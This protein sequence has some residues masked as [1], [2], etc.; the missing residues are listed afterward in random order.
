MPTPISATDTELQKPVNVIFQASFLKQAMPCA[1]Y[2]LGTK[3]GQ[4]SKNGGSATVK[5]RRINALTPST[6]ALSELTGNASYMQ[7]RSSTTLGTTDVTATVAK[8]GEFVILNEEV[9]VFSFSTQMNEIFIALGIM[10][11][12]SANMLQRNIVEDNATLLY[13]SG[14]SDGDTDSAITLNSIKS[15]VNRLVKNSARTFSPSANGSQN[16]GTTPILKS[17]WG[18]CHPDVASDIEGLAGFKGVETYAGQV[19]TMSGE[20]GYL[21][22]NGYGVRFVQSEDA[23][24]DSGLGAATSSTGLRGS[25]NIDLYTTV[26]YGQEAL[27]SVGLGKSH[28]DGIYMAGDK[29]DAI[30]IIPKDRKQGG[31]SDPLEEISTIGYKFW[32]AGAVL[33]SSWVR[34]IRSGATDIQA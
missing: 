16:V 23:S 4:L 29:L 9:D 3:S 33:N 25:T 31:T 11:G 10:A 1:P 18:L 21:K 13:A 30:D 32:H 28:T 6:T 15:V 2:F 20:F 8:Y 27:G 24:L 7:G 26:I 19:A 34:G 14:T 22:A 12:R 5:W 17:F